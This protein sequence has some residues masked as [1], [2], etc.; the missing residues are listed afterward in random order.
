MAGL[1]PRDRCI[2]DSLILNRNRCGSV[3]NNDP[4]QAAPEAG[5]V[6]NNHWIQDS[7]ILNRN[8]LMMPTNRRTVDSSHEARVP[9]DVIEISSHTGEPA[10]SPVSVLRLERKTSAARERRRKEREREASSRPTNG[11][12]SIDVQ[13]LPT[14]SAHQ[15]VDSKPKPKK[16]HDR[17]GE[18][19][20]VTS[21]AL[22]QLTEERRQRLRSKR[23]STSD[24]QL[25][26]VDSDS[27]AQ[28]LVSRVQYSGPLFVGRYQW[29]TRCDGRMWKNVDRSVNAEIELSFCDV[30]NDYYA[31]KNPKTSENIEFFF[32]ERTFRED[33]SHGERT[34]RLRRH[35]VDIENDVVALMKVGFLKDTMWQW[36]WD[37]GDNEWQAFASEH[38]SSTERM[39]SDVEHCVLNDRYLTSGEIESRYSGDRKSKRHF[40]C[41]IRRRGQAEL[42]YRID[43]DRMT[44][45]NL[46]TDVERRIRRRPAWFRSSET[47][48]DPM[49]QTI[50][51]L[52]DM[53]VNYPSLW[54][55]NPA[56]VCGSRYQLIPVFRNDPMADEYLMVVRL[57]SKSMSS[58][59]PKTI[60]RIQNR[61]LWKEFVRFQRQMEKR[62]G[63]KVDPRR[64]FHGTNE[65]SV[66]PICEQGFDFRISGLSVGTKYGKGSYFASSAKFS[67]DYTEC[68]KMFIVQV[69]FTARRITLLKVCRRW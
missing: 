39:T 62:I 58:V 68:Q 1:E 16:S 55:S 52:S 10:V 28:S 66:R 29:Q 19:S 44:Q 41:S 25:S 33:T 47:Y 17:S 26:D 59:K 69:S 61:Y 54:S 48:L 31:T 7:L 45:V 60:W 23:T 15:V 13:V 46:A 18:E 20:T 37:S 21:A 34:G 50:L 12:P 27:S 6:P 32:D 4:P 14:T 11:P 42:N 24:E 35:E 3:E 30:K 63:R 49:L 2:V 65:R 38:A 22:I 56:S 64:L 43:F 53:A 8:R 36:Y 5:K 51:N 40:R 9:H 57:F 67:A